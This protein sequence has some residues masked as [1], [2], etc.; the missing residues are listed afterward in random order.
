[1]FYADADEFEWFVPSAILPDELRRSLNVI[2]QFLEIPLDLAGKKA[3]DLLSKKTR[4]R[5]RAR[6]SPS[7]SDSDTEEEQPKEK[8]KREKKLKE[9]EIY[10]SAQFI[11]DSDEEYGDMEAFLEKEKEL[12]ER[13]SKAAI[14]GGKIGTMKATGT[15]RRRGKNDRGG[16]GKKKRKDEPDDIEALAMS[17]GDDDLIDVIGGPDDGDTP[18]PSSHVSSKSRP[19]PRPKPRPRSSTPPVISDA[20]GPPTSPAVEVAPANMTSMDSDEDPVNSAKTFKK[21]SRIIISDDEE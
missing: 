7:N 4:R 19:K 17:D 14:E 11:E 15:K 2:N 8:K 13:T 1:M 16:K 6:R 5:R 9:K 21:K 18:S 10:K 12:R 20:P 3:K